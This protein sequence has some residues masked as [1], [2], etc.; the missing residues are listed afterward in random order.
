MTRSP[1]PGHGTALVDQDERTGRCVRAEILA[2]DV[3]LEIFEDGKRNLGGRERCS[4]LAAVGNPEDSDTVDY[5]RPA[6]LAQTDEQV[7]GG[8][9]HE[10]QQDGTGVGGRRQHVLRLGVVDS[11]PVEVGCGVPSVEHT[12][13]WLAGR[14]NRPERNR[15]TITHT[16]KTLKWVCPV[17]AGMPGAV[18]L[19]GDTVTLQTLAEEDVPFLTELV[20]HPD[21][22]PNL[23]QYAPVTQRDEQQWLES[24]S[25]S[26]EVHLLVCVE[27]EPMGIVGLNDLNATWGTA[28]LGYMLHPDHWGNGYM[29]DAARRLVRYGF[30]QRRLH[31]VAANAFATNP[32]SQRVLEKVGF[33]QEGHFR[34]HVYIDGEYVD[35]YRYGVLSEHLE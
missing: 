26:D 30:D 14:K 32:A 34:E 33:E 16:S 29:T 15:V 12:G 31:K 27:N 4:L 9:G 1:G 3:P 24:L 22:W 18:Y 23:S 7:V 5:G 25:D 2:R 28:E 19:H 21:V 20:N 13:G 17:G 8:V 6:N 35:V 10:R 11:W